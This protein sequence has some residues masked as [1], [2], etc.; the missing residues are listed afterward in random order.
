MSTSWMVHKPYIELTR[1]NSSFK[2][3]T[4]GGEVVP[5]NAGCVHLM[6]RLSCDCRR[7]HA[8]GPISTIICLFFPWE[9]SGRQK[10]ESKKNMKNQSYKNIPSVPW[11]MMPARMPG[12]R[13]LR[14]STCPTACMQCVVASGAGDGYSACIFIKLQTAT[15]GQVLFDIFGCR[16]TRNRQDKQIWF[17]TTASHLRCEGG[18]GYIYCVVCGTLV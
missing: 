1:K 17:Q 3:P 5:W 15:Y 16:K 7:S 11:P 10:L 12:Q 18:C 8:W 6:A 9:F 4:A 13:K 2:P 14:N